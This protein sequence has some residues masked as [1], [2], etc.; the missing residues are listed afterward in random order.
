MATVTYGPTVAVTAKPQEPVHRRRPPPVNYETRKAMNAAREEKNEKICARIDKWQA[1]TRGFAEE[2]SDEFGKTPEYF[3]QLLL[4]NMSYAKN[5]RKP[6]AYNAWSSKI[7]KDA[8]QGFR[9]PS[10]VIG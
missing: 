3:L 1:I 9:S 10:V 5:P 4:S 7:L 6:N 2:M 8:N